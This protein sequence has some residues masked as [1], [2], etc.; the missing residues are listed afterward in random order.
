LEDNIFSGGYFMGILNTVIEFSYYLLSAFIAFVLIREI[1]K[2]EN[3]QEAV[4]YSVILV[5][6]ILRILRIK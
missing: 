1:Y 2:T 4:L 5:P 6:F 3:Y